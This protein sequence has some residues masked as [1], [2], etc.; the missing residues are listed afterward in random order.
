MPANIKRRHIADVLE[1]DLAYDR[2]A[3]LGIEKA[4]LGVTRESPVEPRSFF[5][6]K[7]VTSKHQL[8]T[9]QVDAE[10][11]N[12]QAKPGN[13]RRNTRPSGH[14]LLRIN[15]AYVAIGLIFGLLLAVL[16]FSES[17]VRRPVWGFSCFLGGLLLA[18]ICLTDLVS[19]LL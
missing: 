5:N 10:N 4:L 3:V 18:A 19:Y 7:Q 9:Q 17:G 12:K 6:Q 16:G 11:R 13:D 14:R 15:I 1:Y 2:I 8:T